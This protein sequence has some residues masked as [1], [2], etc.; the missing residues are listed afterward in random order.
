MADRE[1][2]P[3]RRPGGV[4]TAVNAREGAS[5]VVDTA[6]NR[7]I[8]LLSGNSRLPFVRPGEKLASRPFWVGRK[9]DVVAVEIGGS[10]APPGAASRDRG[11]GVPVRKYYVN[12]RDDNGPKIA[13]WMSSR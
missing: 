10:G 5:G 3:A 7:R 4:R 12:A 9:V 8:R 13:Q 1:A 2:P 11:V 6:T